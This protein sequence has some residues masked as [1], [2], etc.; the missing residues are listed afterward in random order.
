MHCGAELAINAYGT[1]EGVKKAWDSR[2]RSPQEIGDKL[3]SNGF[4]K[5]SESP[6]KKFSTWRRPDGR[7]LSWNRRTNLIL[8]KASGEEWI[9]ELS[10]GGPGSGCQG[11]NCGRKPGYEWKVS[12]PPSG[13]Y[14]SFEKREWPRAHYETGEPAAMLHSEDEY[15]P[16]DVKTGNHKPLTLRVAD[17][18]QTPWQWRK[19]KGQFST[20][21]Q[22]KDAF[23]SIVK[24]HPEIMPKQKG[25][26]QQ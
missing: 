15:N 2:G 21:Q 20:L 23:N 5:T 14:H 18:S 11:S 8:H 24:Q 10:A 26:S 7:E 25:E 16:A 6:N 12:D 4:R 1:S 22:A 13:R 17:H 19:A 9:P 3:R